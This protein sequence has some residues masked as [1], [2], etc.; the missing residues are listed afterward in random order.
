MGHILLVLR[1]VPRPWH[2]VQSARGRG[3]GRFVIFVVA[4]LQS[5]ALVLVEYQA[6]VVPV[7]ERRDGFHDRGTRR[8]V[9]AHDEQH[10]SDRVSERTRI[11]GQQ[12]RRRIENYDGARFLAQRL[13]YD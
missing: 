1:H 4:L 6:D 3:A 10:L 13:Q 8:G 9:S 2:A 11:R 12:D 5:R 7:T